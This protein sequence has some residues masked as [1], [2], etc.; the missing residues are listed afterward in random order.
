MQKSAQIRFYEELNDFLPV[1]RKKTQF[2]YFFECN[3]SIKDVIEAIGVPHA[4]VDFILVNSE[5]VTFSY[6][7]RD[8]DNV[9]VYP[10]FESMDISNVTHLREKPL[11][12]PKFI[13]DVHLGKLAKYL[14]IFG[15]DTLYENSYDD[16][17]IIAI[18]SAQKR[19]ILTRDVSLLKNK[20]LTHGYWIRSQNTKDRLIEV[21]R[22]FDLVSNIKPFCRCT[23]CN[24]I[25]K[26]VS[27]ESIMDRLEPKTKRYYDEF[28]KCTSCKKIY[29]KGS[30][31]NEMEVFIEKALKQISQK[32]TNQTGSLKTEN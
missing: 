30:H 17:E 20:S 3:P 11:R 18:S 10:V 4:E 26:K 2:S 16:Y 12:E 14:R 22:R 21:I 8:G 27:K 24:G 23:V 31:Y 28:H 25:I 32:L 7:I 9:S 15:F 5:S 1:V 29:W 13:L 19:A 6:H